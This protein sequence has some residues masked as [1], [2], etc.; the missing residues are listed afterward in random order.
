MG[1]QSQTWLSDVHH[2]SHHPGAAGLVEGRM[3][4]GR[5]SYSPIWENHLKVRVLINR[6]PHMLW[7]SCQYIS[8]KARTHRC[9]IKGKSGS[10]FSHCVTEYPLTACLLSVPATLGSSV[11]EV[12]FHPGEK[13]PSGDMQLLHWF[14]SH[15]CQTGLP[16]LLS[17]LGQKG[18]LDWWILIMYWGTSSSYYIRP[19]SRTKAFSRVLHSTSARVWFWKWLFYVRAC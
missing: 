5:L 15:G 12:Q 3:G 18:F 17:L 13:F 4:C 7:I 1:S 8:P 11:S 2:R 10:G 9:R 16:L 14:E 6:M 19:L